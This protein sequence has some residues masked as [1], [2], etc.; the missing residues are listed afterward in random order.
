MNFVQSRANPNEPQTE[1]EARQYFRALY[2]T[3]LA[4]GLAE[5]YNEWK[6]SRKYAGEK[7]P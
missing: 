3:V 1:E 2:Q 5:E 4:A 6:E 7:I